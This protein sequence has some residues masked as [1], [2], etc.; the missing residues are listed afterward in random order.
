MKIKE[1]TYSK[2]NDFK[3]IF[4]CEHCK[5]EFE[6]WGYSDNNYYNNVIPN[7]ICP[8]CGINSNSENEE[9]SRKRLD[10]VYHI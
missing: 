5:H 6:E 8:K 3:A 7:A 2:R 9:Q 10:R 4:Q 1:I